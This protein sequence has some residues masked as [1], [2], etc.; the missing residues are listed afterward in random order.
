MLQFL[1][2]RNPFDGGDDLKNISTGEV[3]SKMVNVDQS[4]TMG[5]AILKKR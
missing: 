5:E 2:E 4:K 3:A 1:V